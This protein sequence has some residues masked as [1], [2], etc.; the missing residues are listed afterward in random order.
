MAADDSLASIVAA[1]AA[2][3][4][5]SR[6][7]RLPMPCD[8]ARRFATTYYIDAGDAA[9][10]LGRVAFEAERLFYHAT[11]SRLEVGY[12]RALISAA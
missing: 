7:R 2:H 12:Y 5:I 9:D 1:D 8:A 3:F 10:I 6:R 4:A 11:L